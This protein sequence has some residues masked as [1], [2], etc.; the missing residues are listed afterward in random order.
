VIYED[1][2]TDVPASVRYSY[3]KAGFEQDVI[4]NGQLPTC[5]SYGMDPKTTMLQ[6]LTEFL[7]PP[8]PIVTKNQVKLKAGAMT[9]DSELDFGAFKMGHG[10]AFLIGAAANASDATVT[11]QWLLLDGRQVLV[12]QV[13]LQDVQAEIEALP[14]ANENGDGS[15]AAPVKKSVRH[16]ASN[17]RLLPEPKR[18]N[19]SDHKMETASLSLPEKSLVIDYLTMASSATNFVFQ[20]DTTYYISSTVNLSGSAVF[21]GGTVLKYSTNGMIALAS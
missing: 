14:A 11:K 7:D 4:L 17:K 12:E 1:A 3:T 18:A 9:E 21:E 13:Y 19:V 20:S 16:V 5:Q 10:K 6:V 2:F 15:S 8:Q